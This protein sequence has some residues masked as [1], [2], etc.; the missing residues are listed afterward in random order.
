[1]LRRDQ[2]FFGASYLDFPYLDRKYTDALT[3]WMNER[4]NP[5]NRFDAGDVHKAFEVLGYRPEML[6]NVMKDFALRIEKSSGLK[7][8][9]QYEAQVLRE[10]LWEDY[11]RDFSQLTPLQKAT[12]GLMIERGERFV[13]FAAE[14]LS[15][16]STV[17][18]VTVQANEM[19]AALDALRQKNIIWHSARATY[20]LEDQSMA[21]WFVERQKKP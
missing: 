10:R 3:S 5:D 13:P 4:M 15:A 11:D 16:M 7:H 21:D 19:Q 1:M 2:P 18:G 9:L 12:L 20:T 17:C 6:E 8:T 14:T